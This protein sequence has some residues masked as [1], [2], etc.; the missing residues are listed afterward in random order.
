MVISTTLLTTI[1]SPERSS[2]RGKS[3]RRADIS[4]HGAF[5]TGSGKSV[6]NRTFSS[7]F[8]VSSAAGGIQRIMISTK[9]PTTTGSAAKNSKLGNTA[10]EHPE[11]AV[12]FQATTKTT[13]A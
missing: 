3:A 12:D 7:T 2:I 1:G 6:R 13:T 11:E 10:S 9:S 4:P 8:A 5:H